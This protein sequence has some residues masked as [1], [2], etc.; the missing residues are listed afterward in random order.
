MR[1]CVAHCLH[2]EIPS[3]CCEWIELNMRWDEKRWDEMRGTRCVLRCVAFQRS[4]RI[5]RE[6]EAVRGGSL[7]IDS[8]SCVYSIRLSWGPSRLN[9][10]ELS[11]SCSCYS[12][13]T[14]LQY[15]IARAE[16]NN[17]YGNS[18]AN[19]CRTVKYIIKNFIINTHI[20][21]FIGSAIIWHDMSDWNEFYQ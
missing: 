17:G 21:L 9:W 11:V 19:D 5:E 20:Y 15:R 4:V 1:E 16:V 3:D 14:L 8:I 6:I 18:S 13:V 10:I 7:S 2:W 12:W